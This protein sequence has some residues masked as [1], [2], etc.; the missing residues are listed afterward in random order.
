MQ[1]S[2]LLNVILLSV[3]DFYVFLKAEMQFFV[4]CAKGNGFSQPFLVMLLGAKIVKSSIWHQI[5]PGFG[6]E[7]CSLVPGLL[8]GTWG[9][10]KN[11]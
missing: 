8:T 2:S 7:W 10:F 6:L 5:E 1:F 4:L 11:L 9:A 3:T